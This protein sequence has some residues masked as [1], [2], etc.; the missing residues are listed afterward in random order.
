VDQATVD[1]E[2]DK[3]GDEECPWIF[4]E[5]AGKGCTDS[6]HSVEHEGFGNAVADTEYQ[7]SQDIE[8]A[9]SVGCGM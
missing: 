7:D 1:H 3:A 2:E 4:G 9:A 8:L 5:P 6:K